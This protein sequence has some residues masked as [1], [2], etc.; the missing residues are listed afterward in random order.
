VPRSLQ[1]A[2]RAI[3]SITLADDIPREFSVALPARPE[4]AP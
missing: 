3:L 4:Y 2:R 1:R